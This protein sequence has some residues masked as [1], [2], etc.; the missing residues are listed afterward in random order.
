MLTLEHWR[1]PHAHAHAHPHTH[2]H[3]HTPTRT[4]TPTHTHTHTVDVRGKS[5]PTCR[6]QIARWLSFSLSNWQSI[7]C[8]YRVTYYHRLRVKK[9][10]STS[11]KQHVGTMSNSAL[12]HFLNHV[13]QMV[14][15]VYMLMLM[16]TCVHVNVHVKYKLCS[17]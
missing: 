7:Q 5:S 11:S 2:T 3:T 6:L 8:V 4:P 9:P 17:D 14:N 13:L 15:H 16:F 1:H 12:L 10:T